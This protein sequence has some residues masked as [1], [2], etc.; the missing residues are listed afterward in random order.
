MK[1]K[2]TIS[3]AKAIIKEYEFIKNSDGYPNFESEFKLYES[4]CRLNA[5]MDRLAGH[6]VIE[7]AESRAIVDE[8]KRMVKKKS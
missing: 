4:C 5:I 6:S 3:E 1:I 2:M 7:P 8:A